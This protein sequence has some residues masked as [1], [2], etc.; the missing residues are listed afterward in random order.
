[1][2]TAHFKFSSTASFSLQQSSPT[3]LDFL[4]IVS[5]FSSSSRFD[6]FASRQ[7]LTDTSPAVFAPSSSC[8]SETQSSSFYGF[9]SSRS[10]RRFLRFLLQL[11]FPWSLPGGQCWSVTTILWSIIVSLLSCNVLMSCTICYTLKYAGS[12]SGLIWVTL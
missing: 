7:P 8:C 3:A 9:Y 4:V 5:D 6:F 2:P 1:M 11:E 10:C 12:K